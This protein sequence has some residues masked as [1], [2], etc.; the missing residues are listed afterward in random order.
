[1]LKN[2]L[3]KCKN[4]PLLGTGI[5]LALI[6]VILIGA[7]LYDYYK[8]SR[9][10]EELANSYVT[11]NSK[12]TD[13]TGSDSIKDKDP[14]KARTEINKEEW[15]EAYPA[16]PVINWTGLKNEIPDLVAWLEVPCTNISYPV[17]QGA[18]NG[19][20]LHQA[21]TG[22]YSGSGSIFLD[23]ENDKTF[24]DLHTIIYGHNMRDGSMFASLNSLSKE[25]IESCP[26]LWICT[27][28]KDIVYQVV[29]IHSAETEGETFTLFHPEGTTAGKEFTEWMMNEIAKSDYDLGKAEEALDKFLTLSTCTPSSN[30]NRTVLQARM[31]KT[32]GK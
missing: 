29:S 9:A 16:P 23:A 31:L 13:S 18:D 12:D 32:Y 14:D 25:E 28:T 20:Y 8:A 24:G 11:S 7:K 5:L 22:G 15:T 30:Q 1:M 3:R 27:P 17:V 19:E 21:P 4:E 10:Y 2:F 26:Y 6:G